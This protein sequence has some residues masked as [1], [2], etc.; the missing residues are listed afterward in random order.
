M[1]LIWSA[2]DE[3][4]QVAKAGKDESSEVQKQDYES[5]VQSKPIYLINWGGQSFQKSLNTDL[6]CAPLRS[7]KEFMVQIGWICLIWLWD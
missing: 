2:T 3:S 4:S 5:V 7:S 1:L 6:W